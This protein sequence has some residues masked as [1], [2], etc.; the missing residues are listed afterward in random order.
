MELLAHTLSSSH[1]FHLSELL[2]SSRSCHY[3]SLQPTDELTQD[4]LMGTYEALVQQKIPRGIGGQYELRFICTVNECV[5]SKSFRDLKCPYAHVN[6]WDAFAIPGS[7]GGRGV[8]AVVEA[9]LAFTKKWC[10]MLKWEEQ[11][12]LEGWRDRTRILHP[13][14]SY[15]GGAMDFEKTALGRH[16]IDNEQ[17]IS[18][19]KLIDCQ[20]GI[21]GE[22]YIYFDPARDSKIIHAFNKIAWAAKLNWGM[23]LGESKVPK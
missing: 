23:K 14:E 4:A 6:F 1:I 16:T 22:D 18:H 3:N 12:I 21:F 13:F 10:I 8:A 5:G 19:G 7:A 9:G 20:G 2:S 17:I 15:C 11:G